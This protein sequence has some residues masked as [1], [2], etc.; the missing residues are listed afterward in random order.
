VLEVFVA[1]GCE[2]CR[3]ARELAARAAVEF[4]EVVV[5]VIDFDREPTRAP[6]SVFAVPAFVLHGTLLSLGNP[7]WERLAEALRAL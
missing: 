3:H 4:P 2:T 6:E 7:T 5:E 1:P